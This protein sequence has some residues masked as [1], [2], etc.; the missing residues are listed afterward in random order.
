MVVR[1][2]LAVHPHHSW[3]ERHRRR[4]ASIR[5]KGAVMDWRGIIWIAIAAALLEASRQT[6]TIADKRARPIK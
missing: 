6:S 4:I 2:V 3:R 5:S 1:H